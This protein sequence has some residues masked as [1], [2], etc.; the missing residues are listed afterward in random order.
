MIGL[1]ISVSDPD[2]YGSAL[3]CLPHLDSQHN[4]A[5]P[6]RPG[7][8]DL[9]GHFLLTVRSRKYIPGGGLEP[10]LHPHKD[11]RLDPDPK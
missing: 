3:D 10:N 5:D 8:T 4:H 2:L 6:T 9:L 1:W 7:N 11:F